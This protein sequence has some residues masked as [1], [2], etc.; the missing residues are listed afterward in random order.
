M[1]GW[2]G[3]SFLGSGLT[4]STFSKLF[5]NFLLDFLL[6]LH[7]ALEFHI[8]LSHE[9]LEVASHFLKFYLHFPNYFLH[10]Y[11]LILPPKSP[12]KRPSPCWS[13]GNWILCPL[14]SRE[15]SSSVSITAIILIGVCFIFLILRKGWSWVDLASH[16]H[17]HQSQGTQHICI[18]FQQLGMLHIHH[19]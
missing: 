14:T 12:P 9:V 10:Y 8:V 2:V 13:P 17:K 18:L 15:S 7:W 4:Y 19:M 11:W 5:F 16:F 6:F 1:I 3:S